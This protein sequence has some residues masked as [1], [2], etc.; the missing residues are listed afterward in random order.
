MKNLLLPTITAILPPNCR[1]AHIV[2]SECNDLSLLTIT[3]EERFRAVSRD[4]RS[5]VA[6]FSEGGPGLVSCQERKDEEDNYEVDRYSYV[7][8]EVKIH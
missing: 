1:S 8:R 7:C 5:L 2:L 4:L 3:S 6:R